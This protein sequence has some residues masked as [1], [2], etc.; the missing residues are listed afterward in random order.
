MLIK[1]AE[2]LEKTKDIN[3]V[4]FDKTGTLTN[5][6]PEVADI[7]P[8]CKEKEELIKLAKSLSIL[9]H[10]PLSK[11]ISNYDEKIQELEVE[12]FE[13]IKGK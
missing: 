12:D 9:S 4:V 13:E 7:V 11:S 1:N 8:F 3:T 6:K 5:G 2:T 10:H